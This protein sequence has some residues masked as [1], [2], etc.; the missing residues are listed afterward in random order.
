MIRGIQESKE[1]WSLA[2]ITRDFYSNTE[3]KLE[4]YI[5]HLISRASSPSSVET[6]VHQNRRSTRYSKQKTIIFIS[7]SISW[8]G[9]LSSIKWLC[10][11][12]VSLFDC[13]S[14]LKLY[15][16][17]LYC[18]SSRFQSWL[19]FW[20][21]RSASS[22][23]PLTQEVLPS[24]SRGGPSVY[25]RCNTRGSRYKWHSLWR[26][27]HYNKGSPDFHWKQCKFDTFVN[28]LVVTEKISS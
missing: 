7:T 2:R 13:H 21:S 1:R 9:C 17:S 23:F 10:F 8:T 5:L 6:F 26:R 16:I 14:M 24:T 20:E 19:F 27:N 18:P 15:T 25:F 12:R 11:E 28:S 4:N 22:L 3:Q